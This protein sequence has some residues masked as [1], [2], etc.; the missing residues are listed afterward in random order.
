MRQNK[1]L[2]SPTLFNDARQ[3]F[4]NEAQSLKCRTKA[5]LLILLH[6]FVAIFYS[7]KGQNYEFILVFL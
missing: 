6:F 1:T 2:H 4:L 7:Q 3:M 5:Y